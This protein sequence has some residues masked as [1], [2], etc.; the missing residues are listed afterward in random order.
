MVVLLIA[1]PLGMFRPSAMNIMVRFICI[2]YKVG[3]KYFQPPGSSAKSVLPP[4]FPICST[5]IH[6]HIAL[7]TLVVRWTAAQRQRP[8][9]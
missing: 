9:S 1:I 2:E 3:P 8:A 7:N 4:D 6:R 5:G